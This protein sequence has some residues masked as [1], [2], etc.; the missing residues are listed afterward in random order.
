MALLGQ[1]IAAPAEALRAYGATVHVADHAGAGRTASPRPPPRCVAALARAIGAG[2]VGAAATSFG[3]DVLPRAAALLEAGMATEVLAF[4]GE[5]ATVLF[6]R[7]MWAG[8]VVADVEIGHRR[9]GLHH[10]SHRV[11]GGG[12]RRR[13]RGAVQVAVPS[14]SRP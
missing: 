7:P 2:W 4:A 6:R 12:G 9:E 14:T 8:N 13:P 10:P 1:G 3:K 5:G 11:R